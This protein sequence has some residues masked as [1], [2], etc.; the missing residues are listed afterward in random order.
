MAVC[1]HNTGH[2]IPWTC[3]LLLLL[4]KMMQIM[5]IQD[6]AIKVRVSNLPQVMV[7]RPKQ[8][9]PQEVCMDS[10]VTEAEYGGIC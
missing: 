1:T 8:P 3:A 4:L 5:T 10:L 7:S 2:K 9:Q 6:T